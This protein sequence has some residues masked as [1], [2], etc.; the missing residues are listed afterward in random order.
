MLARPEWQLS[1]AAGASISIPGDQTFNPR[2]STKLYILP[3]PIHLQV[4]TAKKL[5]RQ[6]TGGWGQI[7]WS[8]GQ[9]RATKYDRG[10]GGGDG[11]VN[12]LV[13]M[14]GLSE[15]RSN[16]QQWSK[17]IVKGVCSY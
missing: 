14:Q 16:N 7:F 15:W 2:H 6:N 4:F 5:K 10:G 9:G 8:T 13:A 12:N 3:P 11:W 1:P 17:N